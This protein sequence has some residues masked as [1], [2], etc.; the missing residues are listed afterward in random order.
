M[1][2]V[3]S[4]GAVETFDYHSPNCGADIRSWTNNSLA[5]VLDCVTTTSSMKMCY[6]AIAST[7]GRYISL[8]PFFTNIQY[9]RRDV[10][11]DWLM[12]YE[13]FGNAVKLDGVF[14]RPPSSES[15][16]FAATLFTLAEAL[17]ENRL[18]EAHPIQLRPGKLHGVIDGI[19]DLR[20]GRVKATKLV[21][22]V[23]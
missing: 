15:R 20:M 1:D 23:A 2:L 10:Q 12:V 18:L 11:A 21:Y 4:H 6:D 13:L 9:T 14:G 7:G 5:H 16:K 3:R 22:A 8:D 19:D 17:L